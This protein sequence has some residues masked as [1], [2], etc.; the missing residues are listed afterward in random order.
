ML[1]ELVADGVAE[2]RSQVI[3]FAVAE[4]ADTHRRRKIGE[5][6]AAAYREVPQSNEEQAWA[7]AN[8]M[9]LTE[10]EPW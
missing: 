9:A 10:A 8:A 2:S 4:F 6:I 3:R 1:D 5:A 7:H